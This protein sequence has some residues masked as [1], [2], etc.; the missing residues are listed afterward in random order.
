VDEG[1]ARHVGIEVGAVLAFAVDQQVVAIED[2]VIAG[3]QNHPASHRHKWCAAGGDDVEAFVGA[4]AAARRP[5]FANVAASSV[6]ALD[7]KDVVVISEPAVKGDD[8]G[9]GWCDESRE[10]EEN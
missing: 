8:A 5:E 2:R 4:A 9:A 1:R 10:E 7:G 6:R 3:A